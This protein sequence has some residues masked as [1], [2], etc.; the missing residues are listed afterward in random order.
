M[1]L[2]RIDTGAG[3]ATLSGH[4]DAVYSAVWSGDGRRVLSA[5]HDTTV[6]LWDTTTGRCV[7]VLEG[8]TDTVWTVAWHPTHA[9][10]AAS[11]SNDAT[12]R[13]WNVDTGDCLAVLKGHSNSVRYYLHWS[14]NGQQLTSCD[15]NGSIITWDLASVLPAPTNPSEPDRHAEVGVLQRPPPSLLPNAARRMLI[16]RGR[17]SALG[18][19]GSAATMR[20]CQSC[21]RTLRPRGGRKRRS[22]TPCAPSA[23]SGS[24]L[25]I[26]S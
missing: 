14:A 17:P 1:R 10:V 26:T 21:A 23:K 8:H 9:S 12:V 6:R 2:W 7:R 20:P 15:A 25:T 16:P 13:V 24:L 3:E 22:T 5:S 4:T 11:G 18:R 19:S